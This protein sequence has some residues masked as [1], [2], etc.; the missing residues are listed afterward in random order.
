MI[1]SGRNNVCAVIPAAGRSSRM[2]SYKPLL[3]FD[4]DRN[5]IEKIIDEFA[6]FGCKQVVVVVNEEIF[7][8]EWNKTLSERAPGVSI[9]LND[10]LHLE[11]YYSVK[12]GLKELEAC[13]FCFIHNCD[14]PFIDQK[15]LSA[16]FEKRIP[17]GYVSPVYNQK[18]GH[19]VLVSEPIINLIAESS[20]D[21]SNLREIL[22]LFHCRKVNFDSEVILRNINTKKEYRH[23]IGLN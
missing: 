1:K 3:K 10:K 2:N 18:G 13:D 22:S 21:D 16:V 17:D 6:E 14:N 9:I 23:F 4:E 8:S 7:L 19:P 20:E 11:R 5:F 12:S 15:I